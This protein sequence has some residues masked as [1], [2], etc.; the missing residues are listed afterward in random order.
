[1]S[2]ARIR[3]YR[4]ADFD[5]VSNVCVLTAETGGDAT[6]LYSSDDLMPDIF[7]RP[8]VLLNPEWAFVVDEGDRVSGYILCAPHTRD[9]VARYREFWLPS[10]EEKYGRI[11]S[12]GD[13]DQ[14][15]RELGFEPERMINPEV[16]E[17]PAHLHIDVLPHLQG[18]GLGRRL[19]DTLVAALSAAGIP[20]LH[21]TM[22]P[23]NTAARAFYDRYGFI[24]LPSSTAADPVLGVRVP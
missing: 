6:G 9:F 12:T 13:R 21:L 11:A 16:D 24:E 7:A 19:I 8:Y 23:A 15:I 10:L 18:Q 2:E 3:A 17:Y 14:H 22:D 1:M 4:P 20:G 5:A